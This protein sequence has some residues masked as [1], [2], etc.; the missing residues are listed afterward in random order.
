M[1]FR[2]LSTNKPSGDG[3]HAIQMRQSLRAMFLPFIGAVLLTAGCKTK[4]DDK[5]AVAGPLP[6]WEPDAKLLEDLQP[7]TIVE[8]Y[9]CRP[10]KGYSAMSPPANVP[11]AGKLFAWAGPLRRD[12]T[13]PQF[14][15]TIVY[16]PA[17]EAKSFTAEQLLDKRLQAVKGKGVPNLTQTATERGQVNG[18][19]F[20]RAY[21]TGTHVEKPWKMHGFLYVAKEGSTLFYLSSQDVEP[22]HEKA[23]KVAETAALTFKKK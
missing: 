15:V 18:L 12:S 20:V 2:I 23:L 7:A 11:A 21:W 19:T 10:P 1:S 3:E 14:M 4:T 22:N 8:E 13:A 17:E 16:A 9:Q 6:V 5:P